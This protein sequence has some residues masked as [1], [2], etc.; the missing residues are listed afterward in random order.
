MDR[1]AA[2]RLRFQRRD[3]WLPPLLAAGTAL[4]LS[5]LP[6]GEVWP[7][8]PVTF[9]MVVAPLCVGVV[10]FLYEPWLR[11]HLLYALTNQRVLILSGRL[12]PRLRSHD[13]AW[14][15]MLILEQESR[16]RAT[17]VVVEGEPLGGWQAL[18]QDQA[19]ELFKGFRFSRIERPAAVYDLICHTSRDRRAELNRVSTN[20]LIG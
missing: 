14:L 7:V 12:R 17:I 18:A 1:R 4:N 5:S 11:R 10:R 15:P 6:F 13:L 9:V 16:D 8:E 20:A 2:A 19:G 3:L